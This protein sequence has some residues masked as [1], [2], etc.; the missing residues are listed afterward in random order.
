M[1]GDAP[2]SVPPTYG[3]MIRRHPDHPTLFYHE[4]P[5][6]HRELPH[7]FMSGETPVAY[8]HRRPGRKDCRLIVYPGESTYAVRHWESLEDA[9]VR[10][11]GG[12]TA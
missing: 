8:V 12:M 1:E 4:C 10:Q 5:L 6:C 2:V 7:P 9:L 3:T 11:V